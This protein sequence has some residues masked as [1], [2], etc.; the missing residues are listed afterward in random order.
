MNR[1]ARFT[2]RDLEFFKVLFHRVQ[3]L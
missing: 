1:W 2:I 3:L